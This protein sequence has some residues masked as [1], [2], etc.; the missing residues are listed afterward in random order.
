VRRA[1]LEAHAIHPGRSAYNHLLCLA[2]SNGMKRAS[3]V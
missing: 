1:L 3:I 2:Q